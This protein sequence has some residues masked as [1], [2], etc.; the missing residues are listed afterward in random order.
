MMNGPKR[1]SETFNPGDEV[2]VQNEKTKL[3]DTL[4]VVVEK[5][6]DRTYKLKSGRKTLIRN[7]KFIKRSTVPDDSQEAYP[8]EERH[9]SGRRKHPPFEAKINHTTGVTGPVTRSRART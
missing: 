5:V 1:S 9:H 8:L 7:A 3:W 6:N 4:A 2:R